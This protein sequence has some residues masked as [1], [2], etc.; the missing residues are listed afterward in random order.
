MQVSQKYRKSPVGIGGRLPVEVGPT[1]F[2]FLKPSQAQVVAPILYALVQH[3]AA[4][5]PPPL[6]R[7]Y[8]LGIFFVWILTLIG[9][10]WMLL[11]RALLAH[12]LALNLCVGSRLLSLVK[13]L[14]VRATQVYRGA[15]PSSLEL[16]FALR[17]TTQ[18][19]SLAELQLS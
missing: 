16:C 12:I 3:S 10:L 11:L 19:N 9:H 2:R 15:L 8:I 4:A 17:C 7:F 13:Q 6:I 14:T 1:R 18:S 5:V